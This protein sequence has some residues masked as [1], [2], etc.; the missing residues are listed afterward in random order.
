MSR[1]LRYQNPQ[2]YEH[3]ASQYVAGMLTDKVRARIE[4]LVKT[5][6]ELD[7]AIAHW[8]DGFSELHHH[9]QAPDMQTE[10][11]AGIWAGIEQQTEALQAKPINNAENE[12]KK[13]FFSQLF[14][15]QMA[16]MSGALASMVLAVMLWI[17]PVDQ[18]QLPEQLAQNGATA[19]PDYL[20]NMALHGDGKQGVQFI[21]SAYVKNAQEPSRLYIQWPKN[22]T[23]ST[24]VSH[25]NLHLWAE[26]KDSGEL[27]YIGV[28]PEN[29]EQWDLT[30]STWT[31]ITK[32]ARLIMSEDKTI[33]E[34]NIVFSG[35]CLQLS[36]WK[37]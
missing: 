15:W 28:Q 4:T 2:I 32:S 22:Q 8:S 33:T 20:A 29:K 34:Q 11:L 1:C 6:P 18:S 25:K 14:V 31:A 30:K 3:L 26:D 7:R 19:G 35:P 13:G 27:V 10:N 21:I 5:V 23:R 12:E 17:S 37:T 9:M 36:N 16:A 24:T